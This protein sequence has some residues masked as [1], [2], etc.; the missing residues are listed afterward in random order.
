MPSYKT[1]TTEQYQA[2]LSHD[3]GDSFGIKDED[4]ATWFMNQAGARPVINSYGV[5]RDNLL[6]TYIPRLK[7]AFGGAVVFLCTT[8]TEGGGAGNWVNHYMSDTASDGLGCMND[9]IDY[10]KTTFDRHFPPAMSA[11]EVGGAYV[12]DEEGITM[13][14][15][16]AV[17]DGSIGSYFIPS[18]MAGNAWIF[19]EKWCLANQ[20]A[21]P[22]AVYFGNPYDQIIETYKSFGIDPFAASGDPSHD[23]KPNP[24]TP[25]NPPPDTG[26]PSLPDRLEGAFNK[27][28]GAINDA[29]AHDIPLGSSMYY[30][31]DSVKVT[32]KFNNVQHVKFTNGFT[33]FISGL[34]NMDDLGI[35]DPD[36]GHQGSGTKP[37]DKPVPP[38]IPSGKDNKTAQKIWDWCN[39]NQGGWFDTDQ[40]Y[41]AQCVDLVSWINQ[42]VYGFGLDTSGDY[43]KNIYQNPLPSGWHKVEGDPNNDAH[44]KEIWNGLPNGCFVWWT[45]SGAGHV[46]VKAGDWADTFQQNWNTDGSGGPLVRADCGPWTESGGAGFLGAWVP[47][48]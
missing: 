10:I 29:L 15:Y 8:V 35:L 41:G 38:S 9:D 14:V 12:E 44:A 26:K 16:N 11:P 1:Y 25:K 3:F 40:V 47:D 34:L 46:G 21:A 18:T 23:A 19:G 4:L 37:P 5:T 31:N 28:L 36:A 45:N 43:A 42:N 6:S 17:P 39:A 24:D 20:G 27:L 48:N 32:R 22:P 33:D 13:R 7:E 30:F 2:F